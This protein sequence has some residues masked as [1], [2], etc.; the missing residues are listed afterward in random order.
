MRMMNDQRNLNGKK[1]QPARF[2]DFVIRIS[3]G[4]RHSD[5]VIARGS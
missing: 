5:F 2:S 1:I 4:I 3:F